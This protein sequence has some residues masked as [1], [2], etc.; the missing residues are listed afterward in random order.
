[1]TFTQLEYIIALDNR[2]HFAEA[3]QDCFVSQPT[4]SMQVQKLEEELDIK[5]FDR[6]K[7]PVIPTETGRL[8][9][10]QARRIIAERN[11]M[12]ELVNNSKHILAGELRVGIIPT[13]AP[14]LLPLFVQPFTE[15]YPAVRLVVNELTTDNI[16][17]RLRSGK[18]DMGILVTPLQEQ[19]IKEHVLF[20][21]ELM[22][23]V[24]RKN[25]AYKK[26]YMLPQDIDPHKLWLLEEGHCF[27]TQIMN[28]CELQK[29]SRTATHFDYEAGSIE[30]LRR[31]V[32]TNDGITILPELATLGMTNRQLSQIRYFKRPSPMRE[33]SIVV[34]RDF[35][36]KNLVDIVR[37][38]ILESLPDKVTTNK[39]RHVVGIT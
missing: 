23:Y 11:R 10:E 7:Q 12:T 30:T 6:S 36:K 18:I 35:V 20:Y 8:L 19:G 13:L 9:I 15:S 21:E 38:S 37:S 25:A 16:V 39:S 5:L 22:A 27:R 33:V 17:T 28:F 4:L 24:S 32:D 31:M 26:T 29:A 1:M 3:A 14:Y 2:R 34:H